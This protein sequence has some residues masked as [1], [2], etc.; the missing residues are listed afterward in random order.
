MLE[1]IF[2]LFAAYKQMKGVWRCV[3]ILPKVATLFVVT[4]LDEGIP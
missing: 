1:I 3:T 4:N 2:G